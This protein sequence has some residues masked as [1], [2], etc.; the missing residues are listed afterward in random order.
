MKPNNPIIFLFFNLFFLIGGFVFSQEE[1]PPENKIDYTSDRT[2]ID[3]IN[4]PGAIIL[5]KVNKQVHFIHKGIDVWCDQAVFYD[6]ENFFKAFGNVRMKQGDTINMRSKYA[7]YNG[8]TEFAFASTNVK[9]KS[10][11]N[12]ITTDSLFFDRAKQEAFY[13]SGGTVKD[14]AS[15]IT[16]K[17]GRFFMEQNKFSFVVNVKVVNPEYVINSS[18]LDFYDD[19]GH[20][21]LYG[22]STIVSDASTVYCE[23]GFYDTRGDTGYFVKNSRINYENRILEGDS[24]YFDRNR[25]FASAVNNIK[26]TDTLN[27]SVIKGH[28]AEV[29]RAKDSVFITKR[30]LAITRQE[31]DSVYIHSDTLMITG[32]PE[33]RI[34]RGFYDTRL[35]K[36]NMSGKC[37]SI[38]VNQSSGLTQMIGKPI[39][40]SSN[41]QL[42]GDTI[43]LI[44][45][46]KTEKLDTLKVFYDSFMVQQ[47]SI[48]ASAY[49]QV[50]GKEMYGLFKENELYEVNFIKNTETIYYTRE[51]AGDLIGINK[52]KSSTIK[53]LLDNREIIDVY[54]YTDVD[55]DI[56]PEEEFP[57]NAR[58][59][60]GFIWRGEEQL[61]SVDDLF[62][63]E[64]PVELIKI[65]GIPLPEEEEE[66]FEERDE[67]DPLLNSKS[68]LDADVLRNIPRDTIEPPKREPLSP[69]LDERKQ[70]KRKDKENDE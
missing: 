36:T 17:I 47:D 20:A 13:R 22:P 7:E 3:E 65:T 53:M 16:S 15:T 57:P 12:T 49:N 54:Y 52:T 46:P 1:I 64:G 34:I 50:K 58:K 43:H 21:Y 48:D 8:N 24:L 67:D 9:L 10:P 60:K 35:F 28:Y 18:Q 27:A 63:G 32:K 37:D 45:D 30:A 29:F 2:T 62:S 6:A 40:W 25:S 19:T 31:N 55:G 33:N 4:Y 68:R 61:Y 56:Y 11:N 66:F 38:H 5:R 51:D 44:S 41:N 14:T 59:L 39:V 69:R 70:R 42:T 26:V 23:R